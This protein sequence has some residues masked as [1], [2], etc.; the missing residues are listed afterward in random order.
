[1]LSIPMQVLD[2][3]KNGRK[4]PGQKLKRST[5]IQQRDDS[6]DMCANWIIFL[7]RKQGDG[8]SVKTEI[9]KQLML[10]ME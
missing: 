1:M 9:L 8:G 10:R 5:R 3:G 2:I 4:A 7:A 6:N